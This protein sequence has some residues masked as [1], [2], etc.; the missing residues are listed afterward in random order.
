LRDARLQQQEKLQMSSDQTAIGNPVY[1]TSGGLQAWDSAAS[2]SS[3]NTSGVLTLSIYSAGAFGT[4]YSAGVSY[5]VDGV[6][7]GP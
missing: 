7:T 1:T 4:S 6:L 5:V 2:G 3:S